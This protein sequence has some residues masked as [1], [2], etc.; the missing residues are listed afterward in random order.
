MNQ[1]ARSEFASSKINVSGGF[2]VPS[3]VMRN[4]GGALSVGTDAG[5]ANPATGQAHIDQF[6]GVIGKQDA[7]LVEAFR[8]RDIGTQ[9]GARTLNNLT[10][11][12]VFQVQSSNYIVATKPGE[13]VTATEDS[14]EFTGVTLSPTR[15]SAYTKVTEQMLAQSADD[16]GA[17]LAAD[18]RKAVEG[19]FNADI[20]SAIASASGSAGN[21]YDS[22]RSEPTPLGSRPLGCRRGLG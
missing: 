6:G 22:C 21:T 7:G 19:K 18:I 15:Y 5:P 11:D 1:E 13:G 12:V 4:D 2:S 14:V 17:F 16:M 20:A 8:P 9:I 3:M 10:G